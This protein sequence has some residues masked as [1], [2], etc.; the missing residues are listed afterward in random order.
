MVGK[1]RK[2]CM[3]KPN[4]SNEMMFL[5]CFHNLRAVLKD[6][7]IAKGNRIYRKNSI[8]LPRGL[9]NFNPHGRGA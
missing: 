8:K 6:S 2:E 1:E 7:S 4:K 9:F 5:P 3:L